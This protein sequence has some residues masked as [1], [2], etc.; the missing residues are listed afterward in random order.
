[1]PPSKSPN[2]VAPGKLEQETAEESQ[3]ALLPI[4]RVEVG[5]ANKPCVVFF[6]TGSNTNLVRH[7]F[8][9]E[10][11]LPGTPVTQ[12]LQVTGKQPEQW[13]TFAYRVPLQATSRKIEHV[14]AFGIS[15]I[16][17]DLPPVNLARVAPLFSRVELKDIQRPAD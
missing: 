9:Q 14:I 6:D 3:K 15:D 16:T 10:L 4:Q 17:A 8:A 5:G 1:M 13:E 2:Y 12:H 7:T 11:G